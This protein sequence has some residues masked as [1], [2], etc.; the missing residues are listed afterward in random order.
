MAIKTLFTPRSVGEV[1][2]VKRKRG[3]DLKEFKQYISILSVGLSF[4]SGTL[5]CIY[6]ATLGVPLLITAVFGLGVVIIHFEALKD[7][8]QK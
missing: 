8:V 2:K 6:F 1:K 4:G 7:K 3:I 5:G